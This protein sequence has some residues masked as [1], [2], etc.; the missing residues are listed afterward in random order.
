VRASRSGSIFAA[1]R[2]LSNTR[3]FKSETLRAIRLDTP[4]L[5]GAQRLFTE[6]TKTQLFSDES[7]VLQPIYLID[8][9]IM[10]SDMLQRRSRINRPD[11]P[12]GQ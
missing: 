10:A 3:I 1:S 7:F 12:A 2:R 9:G 11:N 5:V 8:L 4:V 6:A